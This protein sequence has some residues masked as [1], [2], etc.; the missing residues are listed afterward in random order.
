M[1]ILLVVRQTDQYVIISNKNSFDSNKNG[2][3]KD[4]VEKYFVCTARCV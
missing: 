1:A 4:F 2:T 3:W